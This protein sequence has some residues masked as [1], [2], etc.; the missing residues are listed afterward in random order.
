MNE[1]GPVRR[2]GF[3]DA[4]ALAALL[5]DP[6]SLDTA[7]ISALAGQAQAPEV[8]TLSLSPGEG[9]ADLLP[10]G[11]VSGFLL[12]LDP[13]GWRS[14]WGGLLLF[15]GD[16]KRVSGFRPVPGALTLFPASARPLI[17]LITPQGGRR[18]SILGWWS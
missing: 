18:L 9:L 5:H 16:G 7:A 12:D 4:E 1:T 17:S 3:L 11:A 6:G 13:A 10:Q 2:E 8:R 15:Q 14:E